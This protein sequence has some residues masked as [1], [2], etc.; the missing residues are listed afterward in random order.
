MLLNGWI[1]RWMACDFTSF[2]TV[3][4]SVISGRWES[5][6]ENP[7]AVQPHLQYGKAPPPAA[8]E[9]GTA[10]SAGQRLTIFTTG[11]PT[12]LKLAFYKEKQMTNTYVTVT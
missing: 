8:L 2:L 12:V 4:F 1:D 9:P 10:R 3:S 6:D 11:T 7:F 5:H